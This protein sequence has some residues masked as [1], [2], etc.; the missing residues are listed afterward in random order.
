MRKSNLNR[1]IKNYGIT[2]KRDFFYPNN[3]VNIIQ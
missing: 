1:L 3:L 2:S